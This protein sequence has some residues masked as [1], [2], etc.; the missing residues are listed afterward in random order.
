MPKDRS[1]ALDFGKTNAIG[2]KR[3]SGSLWSCAAS[4]SPLTSPGEP[5]HLEDLEMLFHA[6][7][8]QFGVLRTGPLESVGWQGGT[9]EAG[10]STLGTAGPGQRAGSREVKVTIALGWRRRAR[11]VR[12][13]CSV[14]P[15]RGGFL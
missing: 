14:T 8:G 12:P 9:R 11:P 7:H 1:N 15:A 5:P 4:L 3:C 10:L 2:S 13:S 6:L